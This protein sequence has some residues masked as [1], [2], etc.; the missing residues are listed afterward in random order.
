MYM[1]LESLLFS[2]R[3]KLSRL[4]HSSTNINETTSGAAR[5]VV[6]TAP[7]VAAAGS[8]LTNSGIMRG[9]IESTLQDEEEV[10]MEEEQTTQQPSQPVAATQSMRGLATNTG[11]PTAMSQSIQLEQPAAI[12]VQPSFV[13]AMRRLAPRQQNTQM[14]SNIP[15]TN[16]GSFTTAASMLTPSAFPLPSS[17]RFQSRAHISH[18]LQIASSTPLTHNRRFMHQPH[19]HHFL[20]TNNSTKANKAVIQNSMNQSQHP[21]MTMTQ[22]STA[23]MPTAA[24]PPPPLQFTRADGAGSVIIIL[25]DDDDE[26]EDAQ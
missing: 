15:T 12:Q 14:G 10:G 8:I 13:P 11:Q 17:N 21:S 18:P 16:T 24:A 19:T 9:W 5:I 1:Q 22:H 23:T 4:E 2:D 25:P 20:N 6:D 3:L 26:E 7:A